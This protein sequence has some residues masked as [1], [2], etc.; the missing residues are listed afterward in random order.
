[1]LFA[2]E[3]LALDTVVVYVVAHAAAALMILIPLETVV[4][5]IVTV[6]NVVLVL[7]IRI[8]STPMLVLLT[9]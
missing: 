8:Q 9:L 6:V 3:V 5:D 4:I 1:M 7:L 2:L